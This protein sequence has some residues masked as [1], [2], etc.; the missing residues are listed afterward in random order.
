MNAADIQKLVVDLWNGP[1]VPI[2]ETIGQQV[3]LVHPFGPSVIFDLKRA[4]LARSSQDF[5]SHILAPAL[6]ELRKQIT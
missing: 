4:D 1:H 6:S 3:R 2:L 5:S